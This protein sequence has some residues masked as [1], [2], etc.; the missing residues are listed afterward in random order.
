MA[1]MGA[2]WIAQRVLC[3]SEAFRAISPVLQS[4]TFQLPF[5]PSKALT[6]RKLAG[7]IATQEVSP[8]SNKYII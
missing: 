2:L 6:V 4:S 8:L 5:L 7:K 3:F 1:I